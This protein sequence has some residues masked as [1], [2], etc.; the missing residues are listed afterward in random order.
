MEGVTAVTAL[1]MHVLLRLLQRT[2]QT[3]SQQMWISS[4]SNPRQT[5]HAFIQPQSLQT[6]S[7]VKER[8]Q[9]V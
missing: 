3:R 6:V 1:V 2:M 5:F 4:D 9:R 8:F 7:S